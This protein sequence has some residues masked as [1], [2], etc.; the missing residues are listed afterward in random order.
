[1]GDFYES[2]PKYKKKEMAKNIWDC[3]RSL[4]AKTVQFDFAKLLNV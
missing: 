2:R 4:W 3:S 1:L